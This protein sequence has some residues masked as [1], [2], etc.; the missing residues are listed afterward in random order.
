M[1]LKPEEIHKLAQHCGNQLVADSRNHFKVPRA[2]IFE[3]IE[4][5]IRTHFE[6]EKKIEEEAEK[7]LHEKQDQFSGLQKGKALFMIKNQIAKQKD[8]ILSGGSSGRMSPDKI[9]HLAHLIANRLYDDDLMDFPHEDDGAKFFKAL[10][11]KYFSLEDQID[12]KVRAKLL[13]L[14]SPPVEH[15]REWDTLYRKYA[16]EEKKRLGHE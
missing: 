2:K 9:S 11:Q 4:K 3:A 8:F 14:A 12:E 10:L 6:E 5:V 1:R 7:L 16:E 15:S 13:S